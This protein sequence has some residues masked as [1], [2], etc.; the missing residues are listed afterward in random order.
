MV[1][2]QGLSDGRPNAGGD[3]DWSSPSR[4]AGPDHQRPQTS[5]VHRGIDDLAS[6]NAASPHGPLRS[7]QAR[8]E[9]RTPA[10]FQ[11]QNS[12]MHSQAAMPGDDPYGGVSLVRQMSI[13]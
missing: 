11:A 3:I 6:Q 8:D 9:T 7:P 4:F 12:S 5:A 1:Q 2:E 13:N 10:T